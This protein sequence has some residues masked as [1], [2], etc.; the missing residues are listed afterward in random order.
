ME[1]TKKQISVYQKE[2]SSLKEKLD[3]HSGYDKVAELEEKL[4]E[5]IATGIS[6]QKEIKTLNQLQ[7]NQGK[8]LTRIGT[9]QEYENKIKSL[10]EQLKRLKEKSKE[11]DLKNSSVHQNDE[12]IKDFVRGLNEKYQKL[13]I[14]VENLKKQNNSPNLIEIKKEENSEKNSEELK[15]TLRALKSTLEKERILSKK[16]LEI[17]L[18]EMGEIRKKLKETEQENRLNALKL[19]ELTRVIRPSNE[20][21]IQKQNSKR[22]TRE[23][24]SM[25][26]NRPIK[27]VIEPRKNASISVF[28]MLKFKQN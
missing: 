23:N 7:K 8:E 10:N 18:V 14:E 4:K 3:S 5:S 6:L 20:K 13:K 25:I 1:N 17:I 2:I 9:K 19:K 22:S 26:R 15:V 11:I 16:E 28:F 21:N 12:K 24:H 27:T